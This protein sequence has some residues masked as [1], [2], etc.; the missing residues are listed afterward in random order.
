M[1]SCNRSC[2]RADLGQYDAL[3]ELRE[4]SRALDGLCLVIESAVRNG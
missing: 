1:P 2:F 4:V 3:Y